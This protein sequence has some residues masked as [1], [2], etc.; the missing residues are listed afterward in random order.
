MRLTW[1][2]LEKLFII[3]GYSTVAITNQDCAEVTI[4]TPVLYIPP[5]HYHS[6]TC[7]YTASVTDSKTK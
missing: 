5:I 1:L 3:L 6:L 7:W 2:K 4:M